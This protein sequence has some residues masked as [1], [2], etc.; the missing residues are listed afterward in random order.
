MCQ[1]VT[2]VHQ[3]LRKEWQLVLCFYVHLIFSRAMFIVMQQYTKENSLYIETYLAIKTILIL[4]LHTIS[5]KY[6]SQDENILTDLNIKSAHRPGARR[7]FKLLV[8]L[9]CFSWADMD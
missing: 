3:V 7:T 1:A 9:K 8:Y 5:Q 6:I 4:T 2:A